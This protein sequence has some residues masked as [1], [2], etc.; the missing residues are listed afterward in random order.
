MTTTSPSCCGSSAASVDPGSAAATIG[1]IGKGAGPVI[2]AVLASKMDKYVT[3]HSP[4]GTASN[5]TSFAS[6]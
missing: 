6:H 5:A 3:N 4:S 2:G 1:A